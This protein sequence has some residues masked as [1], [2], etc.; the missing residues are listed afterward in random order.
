MCIL[1]DQPLECPRASGSSC[2]S[3][4]VWAESPWADVISAQHLEKGG[5]SFLILIPNFIPPG[6]LF[7]F[8]FFCISKGPDP[9][10]PRAVPPLHPAF[11]K[12]GL[13]SPSPSPSFRSDSSKDK[14][15]EE[16]TLKSPWQW[17]SCKFIGDF[18]SHQPQEHHLP[19]LQLNTGYGIIMVCT[20]VWREE[21]KE[22]RCYN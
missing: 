17:G 22:N 8:P 18:S 15:Y 16:M 14:I 1:L 5:F 10:A 11:L 2:S 4:P 20:G 19:F 12:H 13:W 3:L 6:H 21:E 7:F 9:M